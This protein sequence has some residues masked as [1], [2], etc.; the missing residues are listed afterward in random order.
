MGRVSRAEHAG[1]GSGL[2]AVRGNDPCP[3]L[4]SI[5]VCVVQYLVTLK[6]LPLNGALAWVPAVLCELGKVT[7]HHHRGRF[8]QLYGVGIREREILLHRGMVGLPD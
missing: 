4:G 1:N 8:F 2:T 3:C 5:V 6:L 7:K